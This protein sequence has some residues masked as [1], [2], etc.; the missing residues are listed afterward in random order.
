MADHEA[1]PLAVRLG[2]VVLG[3]ALEREVAAPGTEARV[4][5]RGPVDAALGAPGEDEQGE[6][7]GGGRGEPDGGDGASGEAGGCLDRARGIAASSV[8][9]VVI[10]RS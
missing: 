9:V 7:R 4:A 5:L 1:R 3:V 8:S 10:A 2:R 6:D